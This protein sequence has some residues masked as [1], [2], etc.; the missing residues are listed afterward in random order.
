MSPLEQLC[1]IGSA[2][3]GSAPDL[4]ALE[5]DFG[6]SV[7]QL[8]PMLERKNGFYAFESALLVRPDSAVQG[9]L[10]IREWNAAPLWRDTFSNMAD[11]ALYFAED[12]FGVQFC[13]RDDAIHRF[14]PETGA[15]QEMAPTLDAWAKILLADAEVLT[16][17]SIAHRWQV[18]HGPLPGGSRLVPVIPFVLGGE[19]EVTN[20]HLLEAAKGMRFRASIAVQIR[21][22]PEGTEVKIKLV[23]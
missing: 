5:A 3:L 15:F 21:D 12:I 4:T 14:D 19:F 9:E 8:Q 20:L 10:G 2:A 6:P 23:D 11:D 17:H 13:I 16:G 18:R 7:R 1:R 22:L